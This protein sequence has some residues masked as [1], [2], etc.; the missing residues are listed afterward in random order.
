MSIIVEEENKDEVND[1]DLFDNIVSQMQIIR[2]VNR[3][4]ASTEIILQGVVKRA[5]CSLNEI[6]D[7]L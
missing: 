7:Y 2:D 1:E 5:I 4:A 6:A 3:V